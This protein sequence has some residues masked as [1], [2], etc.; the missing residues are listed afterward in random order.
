MI[1]RTMRNGEF[2]SR[3]DD[4]RRLNPPVYSS[5]TY[6]VP[7]TLIATAQLPNLL[8]LL[9]LF[10]TISNKN[11]NIN[12]EKIDLIFLNICDFFLVV[13]IRIRRL[14]WKINMKLIISLVRDFYEYMK[15]GKVDNSGKLFR[16]G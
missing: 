2:I 7:V 12:I 14:L 5:S 13:R 9:A 10:L 6:R 3:R 8:Y 4:T 1:D 11:L 15:N 16:A